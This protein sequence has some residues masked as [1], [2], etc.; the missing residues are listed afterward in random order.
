[1]MNAAENQYVLIVSVGRSDL[2]CWIPDSSRLRL[3]VF[4]PV[5]PIR[6]SYDSAPRCTFR[7]F[8]DSLR[9]DSAADSEKACID[10]RP[11]SGEDDGDQAAVRTFE[12]HDDI[13]LSSRGRLPAKFDALH[14][15][16]GRL[17][18]Y[19]A[20]L[21]PVV[22]GLK[23]NDVRIAGVLVVDTR[24]EGR[25][26]EPVA[27]GVWIRDYLQEAFFIRPE[28]CVLLNTFP[29][30]DGARAQLEGE[31]DRPEDF[32]VREVVAN[33]LHRNVEA[34]A[35]SMRKDVIP[36]VLTTGGLAP[37][38]D[39]LHSL[40][41]LQ[42]KHLP[43][44]L[45]TPEDR[46]SERGEFDPEVW[47]RLIAKLLEGKAVARAEAFAA[48]ARALSL[49]RR[50]DFAG[51]WASVVLQNRSED[52][53]YW[54]DPLHR[55]AIYFGGGS[56]RPESDWPPTHSSNV[57]RTLESL[58]LR[59][60]NMIQQLK[61]FALNAAFRVEAAL[62]GQ[63]R[64]D[65]R[66]TDA[67]AALCTLID[68]LVV[69]RASQLVSC[70]EVYGLRLDQETGK[71]I[72]EI[73][74]VLSEAKQFDGDKR[75]V[76]GNRDGWFGWDLK[77]DER[78]FEAIYQLDLLL[79]KK[80]PK[81]KTELNRNLRMLRNKATHQALGPEEVSRIDEVATKQGIWSSSTDASIGR[82]ALFKG[83]PIDMALREIGIKGAE[84]TYRELVKTGLIDLLRSETKST[85]LE[86]RAEQR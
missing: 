59:A 7:N 27:S 83:G 69:T 39:L 11:R 76:A 61:N 77:R 66:L 35:T 24:R 45:S 46:N 62:Q 84:D 86:K 31:Y 8:H 37:V 65:L 25:E 73:P 79:R 74:D 21:A 20:K 13:D 40:A 38:K 50:G 60:G 80:R 53:Q 12:L 4:P 43:L 72:G 5:K 41:S 70:G 22:R 47:R 42:F 29:P 44:D 57:E 78:R 36:L 1:M 14:D 33:W 56:T 26:Q 10:D 82:H 64:S 75:R 2:K 6:G 3:E 9:K 55:V 49:V 32:P 58:D 23:A 30:G 34:F 71:V 63:A 51:A 52:D 81:M 85:E 18:L 48:R 15:Q 19:P 67:L 16:E 68:N 28:R 17:I 54:L